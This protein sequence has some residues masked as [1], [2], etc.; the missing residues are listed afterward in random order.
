MNGPADDSSQGRSCP[1]HYRY[2][3]SVFARLPD[4]RAETLY[5]VGGLYGNRPALD[6]ILTLFAREQGAKALVFNGDFNWFNID[7]AGFEIVNKVILSHIALRGNVET[8]LAS[9]ARGAG[10]GCAYPEWVPDNEVRRSNQILEQLR[11]TANRFPAL[12]Q[13]LGQLPMHLVAQVGAARVGVVHGD[14]RSL[15]GWEFDVRALDDPAQREQLNS[16]FAGAE[17]DGFASSH[18]CLPALRGFSVAGRDHWV[19][20][21]GAAGM[22]NFADTNFG[23]LTRISTSGAPPGL[24]LYGLSTADI[25]IDALPILYDQIQWLAEFCTNW[26]PG[27]PGYES[28]YKRIL[29][30][31]DYEVGRAKLRGA[32]T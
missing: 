13:Q 17:V 7:A 1:L 22:P 8:E 28:Y 30:G 31:P 23:L 25:F 10:C 26:P 4:V 32:A 5:V 20:N 12:R 27:S 14:A 2:P 6:A 29:G 24:S 18:T 16:A 11:H 9:D 3:P 19:I 21:N 15:A